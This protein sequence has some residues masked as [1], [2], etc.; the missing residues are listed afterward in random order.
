M[1][2]YLSIY[3]LLFILPVQLLAQQLAFSGATGCGRFATGGRG[4]EVYHVTNLNDAGAGSFRD[5]VSKIGRT[6]VFDIGGVINIKSKVQVASDITIAGQTAPGDGIVIYG[7]G[8]TLS[9]SKNVIMRY[10]RLRGSINMSKGS[11]VLIADHAE[12]MVFDHISVQWGRWDNLHI[13]ESNNIT[14]QYCIIGEAID[15]QRFGALLEIP[16]N[17]TIYNSL[18]I[19]HQSRNPKAKAKIDFVNNVVYNWGVTGFVGG[20]SSAHHYQDL[21]NNYFIAGPNSNASFV[22]QFGPTDHVYQKGNMVDLNKN[23]VLD[24]DSVD[25]KTFIAMN[26]T[27]EP[28]PVIFSPRNYPLL[29]AEEAYQSVVKQAGCSLKRDAVDLRLIGYLT[30]LGKEGV[31][32]KNEQ[33][34]GGQGVIKSGKKLK[35]QDQ[36]GIPDKWESLHQLD[37]KNKMDG[38]ELTQ[39]G[40]SNLEVYLNSLLSTQQK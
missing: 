17:I 22:G 12:D 23:G 1:K 24:G 36:D 32:Y 3:A 6:V 7:E 8:V 9:G 10:L 14:L 39:T 30:S 19:D 20:H 25:N 18:W 31:I 13:K 4:L 5:A 26:A 29:T 33:D 21:V 15:P 38:Q 35:D 11:C 2:K 28:Q 34:A 37:A 16:T 40:Y 27:I